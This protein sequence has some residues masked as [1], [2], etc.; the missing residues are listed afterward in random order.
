M[1]FIAFCG[2]VAGGRYGSSL[3]RREEV[4]D[5]ALTCA[6]TRHQRGCLILKRLPIARFDT[7]RRSHRIASISGANTDDRC[8]TLWSKDGNLRGRPNDRLDFHADRKAPVLVCS[9]HDQSRRTDIR[10]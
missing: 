5:D 6:K 7:G 10:R 2:R 4:I 8:K 3:S 9:F 1:I